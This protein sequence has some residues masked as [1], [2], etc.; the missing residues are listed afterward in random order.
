MKK[1]IIKIMLGWI[2][3]NEPIETTADKLLYLFT[4][5][6]TIISFADWLKEQQIM[7]VETADG[8]KWK[9]HS[10][11]SKYYSSKELYEAFLNKRDIR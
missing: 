4:F 1:E 2:E 10:N 8:M 3:N 11:K 7:L 6:R 9:G 5:K